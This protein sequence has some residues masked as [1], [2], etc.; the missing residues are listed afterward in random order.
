MRMCI[1]V[2]IK[3]LFDCLFIVFTSYI[4]PLRMAFN[5][6]NSFRALSVEM[7]I[8]I[9]IFIS[10]DGHFTPS[11][12]SIIVFITDSCILLYFLYIIVVSSDSEVASDYYTRPSIV[13]L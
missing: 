1:S 5:Y 11:H 10:F 9:Y 13:S 8:R 12:F 2:N 4:T 6:L 3:F 7:C